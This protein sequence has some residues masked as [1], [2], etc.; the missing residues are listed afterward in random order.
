MRPSD[1]WEIPNTQIWPQN[2]KSIYDPFYSLMYLRYEVAQAVFCS[3]YTNLYFI[4][5]TNS[6]FYPAPG[7]DCVSYRK[8]A[9]TGTSN[10]RFRAL[11]HDKKRHLAEARAC[12]CQRIGVCVCV[13]VCVYTHIKTADCKSG[14]DIIIFYWQFNAVSNC[15]LVYIISVKYVIKMKVYLGCIQFESQLH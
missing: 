3:V 7:Y 6:Y 4:R 2:M 10:S 8:P 1:P 12:L 5:V 11:R 15:R 14:I 9:S 13:C